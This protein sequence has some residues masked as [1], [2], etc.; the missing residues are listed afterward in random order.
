MKDSIWQE[1][2]DKGHPNC[3][4]SVCPICLFSKLPPADEVEKKV[5]GIVDDIEKR[6]LKEVMAK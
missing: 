1:K 3:L 6:Y 4:Q 2:H 5:S